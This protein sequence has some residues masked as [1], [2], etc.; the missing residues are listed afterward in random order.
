MVK[1]RISSSKFISLYTQLNKLHFK[2]L[3]LDYTSVAHIC[4]RMLTIALWQQIKKIYREDDL[5]W[6]ST[7]RKDWITEVCQFYFR[8][9]FIWIFFSTIQVPQG[10]F[11]SCSLVKYFHPTTHYLNTA[12]SIHTQFKYHRFHPLWTIVMIGLDFVEGERAT[13]RFF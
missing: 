12:L 13:L 11:S 4:L 10:S 7:P 2:L 5:Q 6:Y 8:C 1:D 9:N 3:R